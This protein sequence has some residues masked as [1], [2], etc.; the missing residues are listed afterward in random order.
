MELAVYD[1]AGRRVTTLVSQRQAP[2]VYR[3]GWHG[4]NGQGEA[5]ASGVYFCRLRVGREQFSKKMVL[6]K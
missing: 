3:V 5:V 4:L 2:G 1:V 6:M